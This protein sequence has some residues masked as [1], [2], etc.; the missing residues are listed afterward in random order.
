M[1]SSKWNGRRETVLCVLS[2]S[3]KVSS[4]C[5]TVPSKWENTGNGVSQILGITYATSAVRKEMEIKCP[6]CIFL[7][8]FQYLA[9][10]LGFLPKRNQR[11]C[12]SFALQRKVLAHFCL[13]IKHGRYGLEALVRGFLC[14]CSLPEVAM[15]L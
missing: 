5:R 1:E 13:T 10:I 2:H 7:T 15:G 9:V 4:L 8:V 12:W 3:L 6:T 14:K 11:S